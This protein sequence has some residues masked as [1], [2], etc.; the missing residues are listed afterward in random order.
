MEDQVTLLEIT[1]AAAREREAARFNNTDPQEQLDLEEL[2]HAASLNT[3]CS[4]AY[5]LGIEELTTI[6]AFDPTNQLAEDIY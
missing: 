3:E 5:E 4:I 6:G 1:A 2:H